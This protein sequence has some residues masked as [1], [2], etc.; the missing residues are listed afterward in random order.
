M[1]VTLPSRDLILDAC[2]GRIQLPHPVLRAAGELAELHRARLSRAAVPGVDCRRVELMHEIDRWVSSAMP[3]AHG[4]AWMHT[5]TVGAVVDRLAQFSVYAYAALE[6]A[7]SQWEMHV[8]WQRLAELSLGYSDMAFEIAAGTL[9]LPDF[10][11]PQVT[12][13]R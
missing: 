12:S 6:Q 1:A 9:R 3:R 8:A 10:G 2:A 11:V 7:D 4:C 5:E 13:P